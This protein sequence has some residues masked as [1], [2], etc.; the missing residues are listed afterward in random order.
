LTVRWQDPQDL[1]NPFDNSQIYSVLKQVM[2]VRY[3]GDAGVNNPGIVRYIQQDLATGAVT[4]VAVDD[5]GGERYWFNEEGETGQAI[6]TVN[7]MLFFESPLDYT[8]ESPNS[9]IEFYIMKGCTGSNCNEQVAR[10][11]NTIRFLGDNRAISTNLGKFNDPISLNQAGTL[12]PF[13]KLSAPLLDIHHICDTTGL[14]LVQHD[15]TSYIFPAIGMIQM[16]NTCTN[17]STSDSEI[18]TYTLSSANFW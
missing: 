13:A 9:P 4:V 6:S 1:F 16:T 12:Q 18:T 7:P 11:S 14:N 5:S 3:N 2:T 8:G 15:S 17:L 10:Y